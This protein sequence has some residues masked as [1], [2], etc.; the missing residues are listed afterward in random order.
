MEEE[1]VAEVMVTGEIDAPVEALWKVVSNFGEIAWM[2]GLDKFEVSGEGPGMIRHVYAGGADAI[3]EQL[4]FIDEDA[5][6]LGY[7]IIVNNPMPV[8]DYHATC[9]AVD[10]GNGRSRLDWGCTFTPTEGVAEDAA[11]G[12]MKGMYPILIG[13]IKEIVEQGG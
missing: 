13:W 7:T 2:Q 9:T 6:R 12:A 10:L 1:P 4:E 3:Q 5:R 8:S 11:G